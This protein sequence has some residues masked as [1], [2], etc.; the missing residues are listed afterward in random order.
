MIRAILTFLIH[1]ISACLGQNRIQFAR[2]IEEV[3][4]CTETHILFI[5]KETEMDKWKVFSLAGDVR[6]IDDQFT[7]VFRW[8]HVGIRSSEATIVVV[9]RPQ[10][11]TLASSKPTI[12]LGSDHRKETSLAESWKLSHNGVPSS[13][14]HFDHF[15]L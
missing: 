7:S 4:Q 8:A 1:P 10:N 13:R 6:Q 3:H 9:C 11:G 12:L 15:R 5:K 2:S 14:D